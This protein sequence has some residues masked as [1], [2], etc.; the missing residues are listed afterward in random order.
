MLIMWQILKARNALIFDRK[1]SSPSEV[2]RR[3]ID[4]L[5][6]YLELQIP[7]KQNPHRI[8]TWRDYLYSRLSSSCTHLTLECQANLYDQ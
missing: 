5:A 1:P 8:K 4:D 3:V 6:R 2:L 7:E